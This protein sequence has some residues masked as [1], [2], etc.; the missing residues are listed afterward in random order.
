MKFNKLIKA[1]FLSTTLVCSTLVYAD[2]TQ[3][4]DTNLVSS[5]KSQI[6]ADKMTSDLHVQVAS[7]DG[8]VTLTG[9]VCPWNSQRSFTP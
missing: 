9:K 4:S 5:I 2:T 7:R 1:A 8:I 3:I 6:A